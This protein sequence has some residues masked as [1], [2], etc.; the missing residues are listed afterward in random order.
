MSINA[1]KMS[2][3]ADSDPEE[4]SDQGLHCLL[5]E[6]LFYEYS[7]TITVLLKIVFSIRGYYS[8]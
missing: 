4:Q 1:S 3:S 5:V 8:H 2:K 7:R 6:K